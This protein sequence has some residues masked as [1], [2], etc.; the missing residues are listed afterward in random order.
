MISFLLHP[1]ETPNCGSRLLRRDLRQALG[2]IITLEVRL[3][4][5]T[6]SILELP[7]SA[8]TLHCHPLPWVCLC[9]DHTGSHKPSRGNERVRR[10]RR[11]GRQGIGAGESGTPPRRSPPRLGEVARSAGQ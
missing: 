7:T 9:N 1:R 8:R 3:D 4:E 10:R 5:Y 6:A 2:S 11:G